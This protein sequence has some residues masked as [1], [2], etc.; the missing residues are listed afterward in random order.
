MEKIKS[1]DD[2]WRLEE[3]SD[4]GF[5]TNGAYVS[6]SRNIKIAS[7][8]AKNYDDENKKSNVY[9]FFTKKGIDVPTFLEKEKI[10][11]VVEIQKDEKSIGFKYSKSKGSET[12]IA[13]NKVK[14]RVVK[15][16]YY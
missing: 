3:S 4:L 2:F 11:T 8:F 1:V 14:G 16:Y 9:V 7:Y 15:Y 10:V 13:F 5:H 12:E 6:A